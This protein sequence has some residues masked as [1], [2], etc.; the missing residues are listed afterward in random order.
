[1]EGKIKKFLFLFVLLIIIPSTFV[2]A[3]TIED[4][5]YIRAENVSFNIDVNQNGVLNINEKFN[6]KTN[7]ESAVFNWPIY[8]KTITNLQVYQDGQAIPINPNQIKRTKDY[9]S[10]T[11]LTNA[12]LNQNWNLKWQQKAEISSEQNQ[13]VLRFLAFK[14]AGVAFD[15]LKITINLPAGI[16]T[17]QISNQIYAIHGVEEFANYQNANQIIYTAKG[18]STFSTI[19][20]I[21]KVPKGSFS[22]PFIDQITNKIASLNISAW[23]LIAIFLPFLTFITLGIY[24]VRKQKLENIK[25]PTKYQNNPPND[26]DPAVLGVLFNHKFSGR[27]LAAA[28]LNLAIKG[29]IYIIDEDGN[30][31]FTEKKDLRDLSDYEIIILNEVLKGKL[32]GG[33]ENIEEDTKEELFSESVTGIWKDIYNRIAGYG[34]F[35]KNPANQ[36]VKI[37]S[38]G[39]VVFLV[40]TMFFF[41]APFFTEQTYVVFLFFGTALT[42][43]VIYSLAANFPK[44]TS[45]G[46][47]V[48]EKWLEFRA[49]LVNMPEVVKYNQIQSDLFIKYLPY[50]IVLGC[51]RRWADHFANAPFKVPEWFT[52]NEN[53]QTLPEFSRRLY[54]FIDQLSG[55]FVEMKDPGRY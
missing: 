54:P 53:I 37:R 35:V 19:V 14:E 11:N 33:I 23:L 42:S 12:S 25:Q 21:A 22:V 47:R 5:G 40:S 1:M 28:I 18:I 17:D 4:M 2:K 29:Y 7:V 41:F 30:F 51:E 20:A 38:F 44:R 34:W 49:Y 13:D 52:S 16:P 27:E 26:L 6:I 24:L 43:L 39:I 45:D 31:R 10:I 48:L 32:S 8:A 36:V 15:N 46:V 55:L 3:Q 50:T 9:I